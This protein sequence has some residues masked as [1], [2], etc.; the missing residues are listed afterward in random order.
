MKGG[1]SSFSEPR[2]Q[3]HELD[4]VINY[5]EVNTPLWARTSGSRGFGS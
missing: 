3:A 5:S 1:L 2:L 4:H